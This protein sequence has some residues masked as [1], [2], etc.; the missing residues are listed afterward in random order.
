VCVCVFGFLS[1]TDF[2]LLSQVIQN[3]PTDCKSILVRSV[4]SDHSDSSSL[5]TKTVPPPLPVFAWNPIISYHVDGNPLLV[6]IIVRNSVCIFTRYYS[7]LYQF[8]LILSSHMH[9][10]F[11]LGNV[12]ANNTSKLEDLCHFS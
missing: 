12:V 9:L 2:K 10:S 4:M 8:F 1:S 6:P 11:A 7:F 5:S 3:S